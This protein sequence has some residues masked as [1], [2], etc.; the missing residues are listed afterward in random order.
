MGSQECFETYNS[1]LKIYTVPI[2]FQCLI[3]VISMI[4]IIPTYYFYIIK[5]KYEFQKDLK[6]ALAIY[7]LAMIL[8]AMIESANWVI[9]QTDFDKSLF[10]W[11][12][13]TIKELNYNVMVFVLFYLMFKIEK[14]RIVL[15]ID[16]EEP[17]MVTSKLIKFIKFTRIFL[18]VT[19]IEFV[20]LTT[21]TVI[22]SLP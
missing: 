22:I 8:R 4:I 17:L 9:C 1:L 5:Q 14:I 19:M 16:N 6:I 13:M 15:N 7:H 12:F 3:M 11:V 21:S 10:S 20:I 18:L 2:P